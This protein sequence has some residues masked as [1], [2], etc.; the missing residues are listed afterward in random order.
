MLLQADVILETTKFLIRDIVSYQDDTKTFVTPFQM[1]V[2]SPNGTSQRSSSLRLK[3][4][5][6][7]PEHF[8]RCV[9]PGMSSLKTPGVAICCLLEVHFEEV[10]K[11]EDLVQNK[12]KKTSKI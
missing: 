1:T 11:H 7:R 6:A 3:P 5:S 12:N 10:P 8:L 4:Q 9:W 2:R